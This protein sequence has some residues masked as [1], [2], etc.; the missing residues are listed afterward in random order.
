MSMHLVL[1]LVLVNEFLFR[2]RLVLVRKKKVVDD[3][4]DGNLSLTK[5]TLVADVKGKSFKPLFFAVLFLPLIQINSKC[6]NK[7]FRT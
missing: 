1:V 6:K 3:N 7:Y 5:L 2:Y 4:Y